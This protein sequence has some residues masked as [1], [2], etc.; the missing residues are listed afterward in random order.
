MGVHHGSNVAGDHS[1]VLDE[2][3]LSGLV[4]HSRNPLSISL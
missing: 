3:P 2:K 4:S 1:R